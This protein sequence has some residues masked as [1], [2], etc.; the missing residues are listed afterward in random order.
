MGRPV[1]IKF[2]FELCAPFIST[3]SSDQR[4]VVTQVPGSNV[5]DTL[6]EERQARCGDQ[7]PIE[8][9][10]NRLRL[11]H[12]TPS[13]GGSRSGHLLKRSGINKFIEI[14]HRHGILG[15]GT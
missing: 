9:T 13:I 3:E 10:Q 14:Q 1:V 15:R 5:H 6:G 2:E 8:V 4:G 7:S 12:I 11:V